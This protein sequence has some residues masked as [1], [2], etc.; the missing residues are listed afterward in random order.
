[1]GTIEQQAAA[2][3]ARSEAYVLTKLI[4]GYPAK[5]A[6]PNTPPSEP[7]KPKR[8]SDDAQ[9]DLD[10]AYQRQKELEKFADSAPKAYA[11]MEGKAQNARIQNKG[12]PRALGDEVPR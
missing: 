4:A 2:S 5:P 9:R 3:C 10:E 12:E 6:A 8:T 1:M 11:V 7:E